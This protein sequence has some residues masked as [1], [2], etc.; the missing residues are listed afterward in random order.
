MAGSLQGKSSFIR[1][2]QTAHSLQ[3]APSKMEQWQ[4]LLKGNSLKG[5]SRPS[6]IRSC[7][8]PHAVNADF[9]GTFSAEG[10]PSPSSEKTPLFS[11]IHAAQTAVPGAGGHSLLDTPI[12]LRTSCSSEP[13]HPVHDDFCS[14][15]PAKRATQDSHGPLQSINRSYNSVEK[16][17]SPG[18]TPAHPQHTST[19]N[20]KAQEATQSPTANDW[21][22]VLNLWEPSLVSSQPACVRRSRSQ[23]HEVTQQDPDTESKSHCWNGF[24]GQKLPDSG[25][26]QSGLLG[27]FASTVRATKNQSPLHWQS[28]EARFLPIGTLSQQDL[29]KS[30]IK[31]QETGKQCAATGKCAEPDNCLVGRSSFTGNAAS[32]AMFSGGPN[33]SHPHSHLR[34]VA[35]ADMQTS[36]LAAPGVD[37]TVPVCFPG[38]RAMSPPQLPPSLRPFPHTFTSLQ[39]PLNTHMSPGCGQMQ[40][41]LTHSSM[42]PGYTGML[43]A[44]NTSHPA[45]S[46]QHLQ[47]QSHAIEQVGQY[48]GVGMPAVLHGSQ[49]RPRGSSCHALGRQLLH[50]QEPQSEAEKPRNTFVRCSVQGGGEG[51][52]S[53]FLDV[54]QGTA[55]PFSLSVEGEDKGESFALGDLLATSRQLRRRTGSSTS[56]L[57]HL[58]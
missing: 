49:S 18:G 10:L 15:T 30:A 7:S 5:N 20:P 12:L 1:D 42:V 35:R 16:S 38:N 32:G 50:P 6:L 22:P 24:S 48:A 37:G 54:L 27:S 13:M 40:Y 52:D 8:V 31:Q 17:G 36:T 47:L 28:T 58:P 51:M 34:M 53:G 23:F 9:D 56:G 39:Y 41:G 45:R 25:P 3:D 26:G 46:T 19:S 44:Y 57:N 4:A 33:L 11:A 14:S 29:G 2:I 43:S 55:Q 21:S